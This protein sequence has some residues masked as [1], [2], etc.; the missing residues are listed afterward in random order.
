MGRRKKLPI[1]W[2]TPMSPVL[3]Y[4][5]CCL[6]S[7]FRDIRD[8]ATI[9]GIVVRALAQVGPS[10]A[11]SGARERACPHNWSGVRLRRSSPMRGYGHRG[12]HA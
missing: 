3:K 11:R 5:L 10:Y 12:E 4:L 9:H 7:M 6:L 2:L 8:T 1:R